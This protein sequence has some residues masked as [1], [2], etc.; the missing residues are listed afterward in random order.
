MEL[1]LWWESHRVMGGGSA[2]FKHLD[3]LNSIFLEIS[4]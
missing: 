2:V 4:V 3:P 1:P